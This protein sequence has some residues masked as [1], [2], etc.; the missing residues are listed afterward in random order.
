[1]RIRNLGYALLAVATTACAAGGNSSPAPG[2]AGMAPMTTAQAAVAWPPKAVANPAEG[3]VPN[4]SEDND[5]CLDCHKSIV[6][7]LPANADV[8]NLH[9]L[10]LNSKKV[11]YEGKN[12][13]CVTCHEMTEIV[14]VVVRKEGW[15]NKGDVDHPNTLREPSGY[16]KK[17]IVRNDRS[18]NLYEKMMPTDPH[19]FKPTLKRLVCAECH[20]TD[21]KIK[22][23]YGAPD[24]GS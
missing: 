7:E 12:R 1:M 17:M 20:G 15:F 10:H 14:D 11:A 19:T 22:T 13:S 4:Y 2:A 16:W 3:E 5:W 6:E 9:N 21:S 18:T 23:F 8:D 24:A